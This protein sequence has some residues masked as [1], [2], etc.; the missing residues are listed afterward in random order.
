M[1]ERMAK[2]TCNTIGQ[3]PLWK[4]SMRSDLI[5]TKLNPRMDFRYQISVP[6]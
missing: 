2:F 3:F 5:K 6:V 4:I 1:E